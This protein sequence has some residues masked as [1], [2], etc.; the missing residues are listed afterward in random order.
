MNIKRTIF[1]IAISI[2]SHLSFAQQKSVSQAPDPKTMKLFFEKTY[3]QTDRSYYS[4]GEDVW[5]SAYLVNGRSFS[6]SSSSANL[7]VELI[8][9]D[10]Q[11]L[12]KKTILLNKGLGKGD[13]KLLDYIPTGWYNIR[14]YTNWMRN[15]GNDFVFQK[16]IY[17]TNN[18]KENA[19]YATRNANKKPVGLAETS[20][21]KTINFFPEGGSLVEGVNSLVAFKTNDNL[22]NG[23]KAS[24]SIISSKGDTVTSFQSTEAGMGLL[25]FTPKVNETYLVM[26]FFGKE[27][28]SAALPQILKKGL[29]LHVTNDSLNIK[30]LINAN[31]PMFQEINGKTLSVLI[32][33][34]GENI[35]TGTVKMVK[36]SISISIPTK[37]FPAGIAVITLVDD[38]GK[39]H[40]ERLIFIEGG[41]KVNY[42]VVPNKTVYKSREK[43]IL[44]VKATDIFGLP[45]KTNFSLAAVDGLIPDD[46]GN[47]TSYLLLQSEIKGEIKNPDQY[48]DVK[49]PSRSKQ[50]DLLLLTQGWRNYLWRKLADAT[51]N[52]S[53]L[54]EPGLTIKGL[55]KEKVGNKPLQNMNITLFGSGFSGDKLFTAKT[56]QN[57]HYFIDGLKWYGNQPIKISSQD[58]KGKKGGWL[59]IDSVEKPLQITFKNGLADFAKNIDGEISKRM[60]YNRSYK[61]GDSITLN[62]VDIKADQNKK[63]VLFDQTMLTFGYPEQ[64][65]NITSADY[66]FNGLEHFL[67]TKVNGAYPLDDADSGTSE[68]ISF[69]SNG[70]KIRPRIK[71]NNK[72]ELVGERLDYYSLTMDKINQVKVQHLINND[73]EDVYL[74]TLTIKDDALGE[75]NLHLLNLNLT[76]YYTARDFYSPNYSN[77]A[78]KN[79]DLR[80][81]IFWAPKL[82]TDTKGEANVVF[83]NGD[84]K[85][86]IIIKADG[87]TEKGSAVAAKSTYVIQ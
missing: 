40:C 44:N 60:D 85:G 53:Y 25:T 19:T 16:S 22:G 82:E 12:D 3:L 74:L 6:L 70:K 17:I 51:I 34:A 2:W 73:G 50:L 66:S 41:K 37:N 29:A 33:H 13:F 62:S 14:A 61:F 49:N 59:Q 39:P 24:G 26:G 11:I 77:P 8:S 18:L 65:F 52:V 69:L 57:G 47:I 36:P 64:V 27:K 76:G 67:L 31:E 78:S 68:G 21:K 63:V 42:T 32:K 30:A 20:N 83:Y 75:T 7:Y 38:L 45:V 72:E 1:L 54:P 55:V 15:F 56:D 79:K 9:P 4:A 5:F 81:T 23:L 10:S 43:V 80:T 28:F 46:G 87:I 86:M 84:N 58:I 35:Y 48:F 71:I